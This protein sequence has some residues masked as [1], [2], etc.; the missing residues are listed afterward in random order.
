MTHRTISH[1][2]AINVVQP[3]ED[4]VES[5]VVKDLVHQVEEEK[6]AES[7]KDAWKIPKDKIFYVRLLGKDIKYSLKKTK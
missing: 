7:K 1:S 4:E 3:F 6:V 5:T 2:L